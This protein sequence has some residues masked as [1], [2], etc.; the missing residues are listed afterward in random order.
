MGSFVLKFLMYFSIIFP[1]VD[2]PNIKEHRKLIDDG[3][4]MRIMMRGVKI[5]KQKGGT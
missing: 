5:G 1:Y 4:K 2:N 3:R